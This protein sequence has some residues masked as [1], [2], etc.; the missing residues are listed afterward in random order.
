MTPA[1]HTCVIPVVLALLLMG[2]DD[3]SKQH[4]ENPYASPDSAPADIAQGSV[5]YH[6]APHPAPA[7]TMALLRRGHSEYHAFC[8]P[9]HAETGAGDGMVVQR[10]FP[11]PRPLLTTEEG[12][13]ALPERLYGI[14]TSG[15]G[16]MYGFAQRIVP[17][18]RWA[19]VAYLFA[20][21]RSQHATRADMTPIQQA[22]AQ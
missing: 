11:A 15:Q 20:L 6:D 12:Q 13:P 18:D 22:G 10:G 21:R 4:K 5:E 9:C 14:I 16:I 7:V 1:R 8:V 17:D 2:C 19:I 3:M